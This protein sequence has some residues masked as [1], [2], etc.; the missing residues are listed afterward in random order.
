MSLEHGTVRLVRII[1]RLNIGGPAIQAITLTRLLE[2]LGYETV[3]IRGRESP[4]EG[5]M[6]YLAQELGVVPTLVGSMRRDPGPRD[7]VAVVRLKEILQRYRPQIV[8]THA[9]KAGTL[10]RVAVMVAF[11]SR[12]SRP[13]LVHT[14]HGHSLTGYFSGRTAAMY[15]MIERSLARRTDAL[16]AVSAEVRDELVQLGVAAPD[17]FVIVPLGFNLD[18]FLDDKDRSR[19]RA[20]LR[21]DWGVAA[22]D[23]VVTL[24][25]RLVP[26]KRVDRFLRVAQLIST[27][28]Q[29]RFVVVGDGEL[30]GELI[31]SEAARALRGRLVWAGF[32]RDMPDVCFASDVVILTSDNEGTPVSLIEAQAAAV[33]VVG[34]NVGGV[35][36]AIRA[37]ETGLLAA[38]HDEEGLARAAKSILED[39]VLA[40]KMG[41]AGREHAKSSYSSGR[42]VED[43]HRL[44]R[45]LLAPRSRRRRSKG[46]S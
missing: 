45:Q 21:G 10:G 42:L 1:A 16:I 12:A 6:D 5:S 23:E 27:R 8:H 32:R 25:S 11:P 38:P 9:A 34:T 13:V 36:S 24:V 7:I 29:A 35:R 31:D 46:P 14:F 33:P 26:I 17:K 22:E 15:R 40:M 39:R 19:R 18:P 43:H 4:T 41:E 28:P 20:A 37:G 2:P 30:R 44:Y 3:L